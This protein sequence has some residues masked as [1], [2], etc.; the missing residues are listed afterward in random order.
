M[1]NRKHRK[2]LMQSKR[3]DYDSEPN[4]VSNN[5][6]PATESITSLRHLKKNQ[7]NNVNK[8]LDLMNRLI[9]K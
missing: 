8:E 2:N 4:T 5:Y 9:N 3:E 7:I 1:A 6:T